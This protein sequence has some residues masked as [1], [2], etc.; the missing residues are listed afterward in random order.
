MN[1][2]LTPEQELIQQIAR[3]F[4]RERV[5]PA[6]A[7][8]DEKSEFPRQ[9]LGVLAKTDLCGVYIPEEYGGLGGGMFA[10]CL[11]VEEISRVDSGVA[12]CFAGTGLGTIPILLFGTEEQKSKYLPGVAA[13]K[14]IGAF[15]LTEA[16]AGSDSFA[17][18]TTAEKD[19]D[20]YVLNGTKQW[21]TNGGEADVYTVIAVTNRAKGARGVSALIVE[22]GTPGFSFGKKENKM[23]I[24][25]SST[26]GLVFNNCR[27][28]KEN[29][30]AREGMGLIVVGRTL[31]Q[32]RPGVGA[33]AVGIAQGAL[34]QAVK[35]ARHRV[36]FRQPI[37]QFQAIQHI[38]A[39]MATQTEAARALV[40]SVARAIDSG[41]KGVSKAAAMAKV[42]ASDVAMKV[43]TDAVQVMG[44][45]GY[46][47]DYPVERMM[48]DAKI[49]QIYEGTNQ[50]QRNIIAAELIKERDEW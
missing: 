30:L 44:G 8:L 2:F 38:L 39:D 19:G 48:R 40:Y 13:G 32:S 12:I 7:A 41:A 50:I 24:R 5:A 3:R 1:Y 43:T 10:F 49:T 23:G 14:T 6:S 34:D 26:V 33:Q 4:A 9:L 31:D 45:A 16:N 35:F 47:K 20:Y 17:Q 37:I 29:L 42:F 18:E 27:V 21:I 28:P 11:V 46:M 25:S 22:K 15:A 36:Q